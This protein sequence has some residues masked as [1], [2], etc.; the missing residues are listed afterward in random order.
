MSQKW[1]RNDTKC[2]IGGGVSQKCGKSVNSY[3]NGPLGPYREVL[4]LHIEYFNNV[5]TC[6]FC[7]WRYFS[8]KCPWEFQQALLLGKHE[9][10]CISTKASVSFETSLTRLE[11][12]TNRNSLQLLDNN[13]I[14]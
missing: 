8:D 11:L 1:Q 9:T 2:H 6:N 13:N 10:T 4:G 12:L 3:L 14:I 7:K 5:P